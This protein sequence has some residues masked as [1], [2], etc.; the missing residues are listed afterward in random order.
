MLWTPFYN[1]PR[2]SWHA[3]A[4]AVAFAVA[5]VAMAPVLASANRPGCRHRA[6]CPRSG[7]VRLP[8]DERVAAAVGCGQPDRAQREL[9]LPWLPDGDEVAGAA[10]SAG[11]REHPQAAAR[12]PRHTGELEVDRG[13]HGGKMPEM[14]RRRVEQPDGGGRGAAS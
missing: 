13:W 11:L 3:L 4:F 6:G 9:P 5:G 14:A 7:E 12:G 10:G 1:V 8:D 2:A